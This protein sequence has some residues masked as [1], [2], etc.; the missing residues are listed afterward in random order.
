[1][2]VN[3]ITQ[4][5]VIEWEEREVHISAT[6]NSKFRKRRGSNKV[7]KAKKKE[8]QECVESGSQ[9]KFQE[10]G[11]VNC[12]NIA[13]RLKEKDIEM[14]PLFGTSMMNLTKKRSMER[15]QSLIQSRLK[16]EQ[17][18]IRGESERYPFWDFFFLWREAGKKWVTEKDVE[19]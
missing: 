10:T 2:Q 6:G 3:K 19:S 15:D 11:N 8:N 1:M 17:K 12:I 18:I 14:T 16:C 9:E 7:K 13:K 4:E 5:E